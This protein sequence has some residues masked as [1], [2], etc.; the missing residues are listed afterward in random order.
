MKHLHFLRIAVLTV[1]FPFFANGQEF[2]NG[3]FEDNGKLCLINASTSVFNSNVKNTH[4]FGSFRKPDI[5]SSDCGF[6]AAKDGNWFVGLATNVQGIVRSEA[7]SLK[8]SSELQQGNQYSVS[9]WTRSRSYASNLEIGLS[10]NDSTGGKVFYTVAASSIGMEWTEVS[11]RFTAPQNGQFIT[12]RAMN[13][14]INS[15]VWLDAFHLS[16]VFHPENLVMVSKAE[17]APKATVNNSV[18]KAETTAAIALYPNPSEGI[19]K[20]TADSSQLLSLT[21]YDMV[22]STVEHHVASA[23]QPVP[24]QIDLTMQQPGL[25]FVEMSTVSGDKLTRRIIVSR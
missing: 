24:S 21:V 15:G 2:M 23:S 18:R 22:G 12:V 10:S 11:I 13:P 3:S 19:F 5:A 8:L 1:A 16:T 14:N 25:Y 4:A 9:F 20:V 6:G 17:A 7:I